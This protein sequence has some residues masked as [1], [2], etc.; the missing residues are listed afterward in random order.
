M[1][2]KILTLDNIPVI[3]K[4]IGRIDTIEKLKASTIYS[5]GDVVEVLGFHTKGDGAHH[6]RIAKAED[7][8]SGELGVDGL[9]WCIVSEDKLN[10]LWFGAK[11]DG[12]FDNSEII[13]RVVNCAGKDKIVVFGRG[14]YII[15]NT[16]Q[17]INERVKI[18]GD[19][20]DEYHPMLRIRTP[21]IPMFNCVGF[22]PIFTN[23]CFYGDGE[24]SK[25]HLATNS[26]IVINRDDGTYEETKG[27][28]DAEF[29]FVKFFRFKD[30]IKA[31]G[32]NITIDN[33]VFSNSASAVKLHKYYDSDCRGLIVRN[34]RFHTMCKASGAPNEFYENAFSITTTED[35]RSH[36]I[37]D[38]YIDEGCFNFYKGSIKDSN[39]SENSTGGE[40]KGRF[41]CSENTY[42]YEDYKCVIN[43]NVIQVTTSSQFLKTELSV[44]YINNSVKIGD[45]II[46]GNSILN[47]NSYAVNINGVKRLSLIGNYIKGAFCGSGYGDEE[48]TLLKISS[49]DSGN[50]S[51]NSFLL[52]NIGVE[53]AIVEE[54]TNY[55]GLK[56][57]DNYIGGSASG[58]IKNIIPSSRSTF[59]QELYTSSSKNSSIQ[60]ITP[61]VENSVSLNN[62]SNEFKN[63]FK[64]VINSDSK[65]SGNETTS[66]TYSIMSRGS[67]TEIM[68]FISNRFYLPQLAGNGHKQLYITNDGVITVSST[69]LSLDTP[70]YTRKMQQQGIYDE[71]VAYRDE[72][73]YYENSQTTDETMLLPV[74]QE[75]VIPE[76][77]KQFA[78]KYK[79]I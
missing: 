66:V 61:R 38:N 44:I 51:N 41:I 65:T 35:S 39:I 43:N 5:L 17:I 23:L 62:S 75:P 16:I 15:N 79:L 78:E 2:K 56:Y 1:T 71:Y 54:G 76:S 59:V 70:Y 49:V 9:I 74:L 34:S 45:L 42:S 22:S 19:I 36:I 11:G 12:S 31:T 47:A 14:H 4:N 32:R 58:L 27:N 68:K 72:L 40:F 50:V 7:D 10:V 21:N 55:I 24:N 20:A 53:Y 52:A 64:E 48:K 28:I 37:K 8:G 13:Q 26:C 67:E 25:A 18:T 73:H 33:C 69:M 63:Y 57:S 46:D 6:K 29:R 60:S 3:K 77:V 30:C